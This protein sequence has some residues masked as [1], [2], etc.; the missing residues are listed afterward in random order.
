M[1][2]RKV[3]KFKT[4]IK[5]LIFIDVLIVIGAI[6]GYNYY[7]DYQYKETNEYK[8]SQIRGNSDKEKYTEQEIKTILNK[9]T[10]EEQ[11]DLISR[12]YNEFYPCFIG[13]PYFIYSKLDQ[14]MEYV[15][16]KEKDFF[17]Y[18]GT[19]G[20]DYDKLIGIVNSHAN[21]NPYESDRVSDE[22]KGYGMIANKHYQLG[23][24][25]PDD[26]ESI[27]WKYRFGDANTKIELRSEAHAAYLTM[28]EAAHEEGIYLLALSGYRSKKEQEKEY[29]YYKTYKGEK[30]A[31]SI[32]ARPGWSEHQT[33][34]AL[35][36]YAKENS[37]A[38]TF[39]T[40]NAFKWL[41]E[42]SYKYGFIL[43]YP[44][45]YESITGYNYESWHYRYLGVDL[46]T[47]VME[48]GLT[49]DEY[50]AFYLDK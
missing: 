6:V 37:D 36:I 18:H 8:L 47:K 20:Y 50:Y 9:L 28:W 32:A 12:G 26:L 43:R 22:S 16:T 5:I 29:N 7:K 34:L 45:G 19:E 31:D 10:D 2:K 39:D 46:A 38:K 4:W 13:R 49:Y 27:E 30:Y 24:Y 23:D 25:A 44:K 17:K 3:Y 40:S 48:S 33:G 1:A 35:D 41:S 21:E 15:I 14:Y 11:K 42:N